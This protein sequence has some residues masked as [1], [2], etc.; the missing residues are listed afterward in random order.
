MVVDVIGVKEAMVKYN[1]IVGKM[2]VY[3]EFDVNGVLDVYEVVYVVEIIDY[4]LEKFKKKLKVEKIKVDN[5]VIEV[6]NV[7]DDES[8]AIENVI[9]VEMN[10]MVVEDVMEVIENIIVEEVVEEE[11][12]FKMKMCCCVMKI[13]FE[14]K[15]SG[16]YM[17][18]MT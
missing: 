9:E 12:N 4:V 10:V 3:F 14:V 8:S 5:N 16:L 7:T 1:D 15:V 11:E 18:S 17:E 13:L 2:N 6:I